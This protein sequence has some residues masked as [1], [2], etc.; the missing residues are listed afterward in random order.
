MLSALGLLPRRIDRYYIKDGTLIR[1][2]SLVSPKIARMIAGCH[3]GLPLF[4]SF[5]RFNA[6]T[7][8]GSWAD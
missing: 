6:L 8:G 3:S 5:Q 2:T 7:V 4:I 1:V